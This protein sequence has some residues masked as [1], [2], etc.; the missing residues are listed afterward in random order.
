M[1][2]HPPWMAHTFPVAC[3]GPGSGRTPT[4]EHADT[5]GTIG[6]AAGQSQIGHRRL[7]GPHLQVRHRL[8][9]IAPQP[10]E[11]E[12]RRAAGL[13][14]AIERS[15]QRRAGS[16]SR[17]PRSRVGTDATTSLSKTP[18]RAAGHPE[19]NGLLKI[20]GSQ[21]P[22]HHAKSQISRP[23]HDEVHG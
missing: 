3:R 7:G 2:V 16:Q 5:I 22:L 15:R 21:L 1:P 8:N 14:R 11:I 17:K 20:H 4:I 6:S 19:D 13:R 10:V 18:L 23:Q 9:G 12:H